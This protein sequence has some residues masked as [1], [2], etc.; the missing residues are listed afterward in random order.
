MAVA[1]AMPKQGITVESCILTKWNVKVG[2]TVKEGDILFSFET[3]KSSID[4]AAEASGE[5]LATFFNEGDE[6]PV[7]TNVAVLGKKGE[8]ISA[9]TPNGSAPKAEEV[10]PEEKAEVKSAPKVDP[11]SVN[12]TPVTMPKS[13]ITVESCILTKF[14]VK[15]GDTVKVGNPLFSYETDKSSF[16]LES[17]VAGEVLQIFYNE[18]DEVP[19][20]NNVL[21]IGEHGVDA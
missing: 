14:S 15:V 4:Y 5:V 2:D 10:K 9:F 7:L 19:V 21:A 11:A 6:V 3:D 13:G 1:V 12:A 17:E 20:G 18:G 16:D 8:D